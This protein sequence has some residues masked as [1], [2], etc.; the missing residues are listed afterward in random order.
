MSGDSRSL[1]NF[2][3]VPVVVGDPDG[4]AVYLNP[5]FESRFGTPRA[6]A[7][8]MPLASLFSGGGREAVLRAVAGVC[9]A[10]KPMRFHL[11]EAECGWVARVCPIEAE[12][13]RVGV[14]ILLM[15]EL[16]GDERLLALHR[17]IQEP[18]DEVTGCLDQLLE[19]TGGRRAERY[20]GFVE[21]ALR[22]VGRL[23]KWVDQLRAQVD[24]RGE[25]EP[26]R[27]DPVRVVGNVAASVGPSAQG[28]RVTFDVLVPAKLP[29]LP[30]DG[31]RLEAALVRL[32]RERIGAAPPRTQITLS[33]RGVGSDGTAAVL[34]SI[35]EVFEGPARGALDSTE[36][37]FLREIASALGGALLISADPSVGRT[38][39]I[40]LPTAR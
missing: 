15:E 24:G 38:T 6:K 29:P 1:L 12:D 7:L 36:P 23:R 31:D 13:A 9:E 8:G 34:V 27:F 10:G 20:R 22:A 17:E 28:A 11:R 26:H 25:R 33:A 3:D 19:Q 21:D 16:V 39:S 5:C 35:S 40:R 18:L 30:G 37:P 32:L 2:L 14:I 4:R